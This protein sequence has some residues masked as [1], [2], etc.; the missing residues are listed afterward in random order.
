MKPERWQEIERIFNSALELEPGDREAFLGRA[1]AGDEELHKTVESLLARQQDAER[2]MELPALEME[3]RDMAA[4]PGSVLGPDLS[5]SSLSHYRILDRIGA[6]GMG[7]VYRARDERLGRDVAVKLLPEVFAADLK[8]LARLEREARLL[9]SI[10]HP[11]IAAIYGLE[12]EEEKRFLVLELIKGETLAQR[13]AKGP[14]P[15]EEAL[16]VGCQV[17]EGLAAAHEKGVIHRDLKP[18]NIKITPEGEVKVLDFGLAKLVEAPSGT[19]KTT[20]TTGSTHAGTVLGTAPYMSPEQAKGR[21]LD[22]RT[23]IFSFGSVLYEI[24][25]GKQAFEGD[26]TATILAAVL[27]DSP[28]PAEKLRPDVPADLAHILRRCLEKDREARHPSATAL[29]AELSACRKRLERRKSGVRGFLRRPRFAIPALVLLLALITAG[30]WLA[31][32]NSRARWARDIALPEAARLSEAEEFYGAYQLVRQAERYVPRD[33]RLLELKNQCAVP[34]KVNTTPPGADVYWKDY[35]AADAPWEFLGRSPLKEAWV[36]RQY[37]RWKIAKE[38]Y[39]S[40]EMAAFAPT[41]IPM[42]ATLY[43]TPIAPGMIRVPTGSVSLRVDQPVK[44][45]EYWLD[46]YEVTNRQYKEFMDR[47]GYKDR[48]YWTLD[49]RENGKRIAWAEAM[50]RFRDR[51]GRPGP[52]TWEV[53]AYPEGREDYPVSGVSWY[54]AEAYAEFAG[55]SLPTIY[56]W[57]RASPERNFD[58][59]PLSNF[60]GQ[61]PARIGSHQ[62]LSPYGNY[63]MAG[64][65]KEWCWNEAGGDLRY[66]FGGAWNEPTYMFVDADAQSPFARSDTFGFRCAKY[67]DAAPGPAMAEFRYLRRDYSKEKP[68]SDETFRVYK[69]LFAY[70]RTEMNPAT[71]RIDESSSWRREKLTFNAAYGGERMI[72]VLFLPRDAMAPYQTVIY[73]PGSSAFLQPGKSDSISGSTLDFIMRSGR[74]L[75]W[76]VY[77]GSFERGSGPPRTPITPNRWRDAFIAFSKDLGRTLDYI[78]TR[79]DIDCTMLAYYG[80]SAGAEFG[81]VMVAIDGRFRTAVFVGGGLPP[82]PRAQEVDP[83]HFAPRVRVP[84][85]MVN[86]RYDFSYPFEGYQL[87]LFRLLGVPEADKRHVVF[88]TGHAVPR[89]PRTR[90]VLEWLDRYLGPVRTKG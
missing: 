86:G 70:D 62:G 54:E 39:E 30:T 88:D 72:A 46:R 55:K 68:V 44:L 84:V 61:G 74:A 50:D 26:S 1:C 82:E 45:G 83:I 63:D 5:G 15:L 43:N 78:E 10:S 3:A 40:L 71:E 89:T 12:V 90:E 24:L 59:V 77:K 87:P 4:D 56:H 42:T 9:A 49:F 36:S 51:T 73:F 13:L 8:R 27:R 38:G 66:L 65:I 31:V 85:L 28:P 52:A 18:A 2:F 17:A 35:R 41:S 29:H 75:V 34:V 22:I 16:E 33:S 6:G 64:N 37:L 80:A 69:N 76:P 81:P 20:D 53:G 21:R 58:I 47:G 48:N 32:R 14:L 23:D 19:D 60:G 25:T 7:V 79:A 11:H 67:V 57:R